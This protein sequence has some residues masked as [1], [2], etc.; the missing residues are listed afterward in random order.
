MSVIKV[1]ELVGTSEDGWE[2]ATRAALHE[3]SRTIKNIE[4]VDVTNMSAIV[5]DGEIV[6]WQVDTRIAFRIEDQLR[7][8]HHEHHTAEEKMRM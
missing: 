2:G 8:E 5:E 3:A 1:I 6:E 4:S 7:S